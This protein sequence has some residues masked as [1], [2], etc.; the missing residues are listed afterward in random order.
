MRS[1]ASPHAGLTPAV[2]SCIVIR[3]AFAG[4][5]QY[6]VCKKK[7]SGLELLFLCVLVNHTDD[8]PKITGKPSEKK[9]GEPYGLPY[10][11]NSCE[12]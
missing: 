5:R 11:E 9:S 2:R 1:V 10:L 4:I 8:Q 6:T 3:P 7:T 12:P